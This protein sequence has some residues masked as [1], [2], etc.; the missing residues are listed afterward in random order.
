MLSLMNKQETIKDHRRAVRLLHE[1]GVP[2][3]VLLMMGF[4][5]ET[6]A[7]RQ[8]TLMFL[9]ETKPE[10]FNLAKFTPLP[11]SA[12]PWN[13]ELAFFYPDEDEDWMK[14]REQILE[15]IA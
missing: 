15:A 13:G 4:P 14:Y 6:E 11:G 7:D 5:G 1:A 8:K 2:V 12:I 3:K 9:R 10:S